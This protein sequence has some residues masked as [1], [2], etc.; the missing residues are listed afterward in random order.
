MNRSRRVYMLPMLSLG[1]RAWAVEAVCYIYIYTHI[2][3]ILNASNVTTA[4]GPI[5]L[6]VRK[7]FYYL[8]HIVSRRIV[9]LGA[10]SRRLLP[11]IL[12]FALIIIAV[13]LR[14]EKNMSPYIYPQFGTLKYFFFNV[15]DILRG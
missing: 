8:C 10:F 12:L 14:E 7:L 1:F 2:V 5:R 3:V 13:S 11:K 15:L 4:L 6:T 9:Y